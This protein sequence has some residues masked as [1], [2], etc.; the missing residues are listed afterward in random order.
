MNW[1]LLGNAMTLAV[2]L[3]IF[4]DFDEVAFGTKEA[5]TKVWA[6][7][8]YEER[9][10]RLKH[11]IPVYL[12]QTSTRTGRCHV[13][14]SAAVMSWPK[15]IKEDTSR[16]WVAVC[17][18][19]R[20]MNSRPYAS[21]E[22]TSKLIK[23]GDYRSILCDIQENLKNWKRD[24]DMARLSRVMRA[25]LIIEYC[26]VRVTANSIALH[27]L[28]ELH[29][30]SV[31]GPQH[32]AGAP[33]LELF[34][35]NEPFIAELTIAAKSTLLVIVEDLF[36]DEHVKYIPVRTYCRVLTASV[37]LWKVG[38]GCFQWINILLT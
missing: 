38:P 36:P 32:D 1:F 2:E 31:R 30:K 5:R 16:C 35:H 15:D 12:S 8:T 20:D 37:M 3:G 23:S 18:L 22:L 24:V 33:L 9:A 6:S 10:T 34:K 25:L 17:L 29:D 11:L 7:K 26:H 13:P 19:M 21:R 14:F 27:A 28:A 4:D